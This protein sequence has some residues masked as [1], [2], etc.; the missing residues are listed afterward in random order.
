MKNYYINI[1]NRNIVLTEKQAINLIKSGERMIELS[2]KR[3]K[4]N[5]SVHYFTGLILNE[6]RFIEAIKKEMK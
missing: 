6:K 2:N 3:I 4:E 1:D 5:K